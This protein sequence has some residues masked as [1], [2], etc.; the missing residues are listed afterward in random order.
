MIETKGGL[1]RIETNVATPPQRLS[2]QLARGASEIE[3]AQR[4]RYKVFAEEMGARLG[5]SG[6]LDQ[7]EFDA[8][9]DHLVVRDEE[10]LRIVGTYRIL[11]PHGARAVGR[12]YADGEFDLSRLAYLRPSMI[13][14][15]RSCVHRDYRTGAA[16]M[17]LWAGLA[18]Y[19]RQAG[20]RHLI[21]CGSVPLADGGHQAAWVRHELA[22]VMTDPEYRVFPHHAFP[23]E[24]IDR[25]AA[26]EMPP[27]IKGY[28]RCGARVCGEPA[29]DPDFNSADFLIWLALDAL[30]PRYA[31]HFDLLARQAGRV[32][33]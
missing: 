10:T 25:A 20:Y 2:V 27:L 11:P 16:I 30:E 18:Q 14:I 8:Y 7:D 19:M 28:L 6:G 17:L 3:D 32:A 21:G 31:R 33:R 15:G 23:F 26:G 4:L 1:P 29:W 5:D 22:A 9:C 13:E 12:L 24:R